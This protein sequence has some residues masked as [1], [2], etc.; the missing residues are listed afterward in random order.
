MALRPLHPAIA[1][2]I[3]DDK[4]AYAWDEW[5]VSEYYAFVEDEFDDRIA[6]ISGRGAIALTLA[7]GEWICQRFA[8]LDNDP[9]PM[10]FLEATWAEQMQP[11]LGAYTET[12]DDQWRGVIR[13]PL[14]LVITIANDALF[15]MEEDDDPGNRAAWMANLARHV[16]PSRDAFDKWLAAVLDLLAQHHPK[17]GSKKESL[18]DD[19]FELGRPVARELFDT[20]KPYVRAD[21]P[22]LIT[23]FLQSID[24]RNPFL[25]A[26]QT[27]GG[28]VA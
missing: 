6:T 20:T 9:A 13:G 5:N 26:N 24:P 25:D 27:E 2:G 3:T 23:R 1:A 28:E 14:S 22:A 18:P 7:A 19:E 8:L 10:Q 4:L 12:D 15:C 21:E 17:K 11:G 16:L